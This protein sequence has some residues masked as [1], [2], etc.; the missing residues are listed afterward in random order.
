MPQ[1]VL[2]TIEWLARRG[3][4]ADADALD[5]L[6]PGWRSRGLP[7]ASADYAGATAGGGG[8]IFEQYYAEGASSVD[9]DD[10]ASAMCAD[11]ARQLL[12]ELCVAGAAEAGGDPALE[13]E[14]FSGGRLR[15]VAAPCLS[16]PLP[17]WTLTRDLAAVA[18][19]CDVMITK[20]D[21]ASACGLRSPRAPGS[22]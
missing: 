20:G 19:G 9:C 15:V 1:D 8:A 16:S 14:P 2:C 18:R 10:A 5:K 4:V 13:E 22:P 11:A 6:V 21:G 7:V 17:A 12:R 3:G